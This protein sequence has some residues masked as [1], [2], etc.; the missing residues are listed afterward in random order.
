MLFDKEDE[1]SNPS[2]IYEAVLSNNAN[3][4]N[5]RTFEKNKFKADFKRLYEEQ[6]HRCPYC[7]QEYELEQ[8]IINITSKLEEMKIMAGAD[9]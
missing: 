2:K 7:N 9:I 5:S 3:L 4:L 1:I 6:N 8:N